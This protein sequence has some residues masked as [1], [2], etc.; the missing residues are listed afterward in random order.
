[1]GKRRSSRKIEAFALHARNGTTHVDYHDLFQYLV[2]L[3]PDKRR[4]E[5]DDEV[6]A[7]PVVT[8]TGARICVTASTGEK[9]TNPLVHDMGSGQDEVIQLPQTKFLTDRMHVLIDVETREAAVEYN[10]RG[11]KAWDIARAIESIVSKQNAQYKSLSVELV[12]IVDEG[13]LT[14]I[15]RFGRIR[16]AS[17]TVA[18]P[19]NSWGTHAEQLLKVADGSDARTVEITLTAFKGKSLSVTDGI[20][21]MI[22]EWARLKLPFLQQATLRGTRTDETAESVVSLG[23]YILHQK[24]DVT[25]VD[26]HVDSSE[27]EGKL[28]AFL[29]ARAHRSREGT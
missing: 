7:F 4:S 21:G 27:I 9:G 6:I 16:L 23:H 20:V 28:K 14:A 12:P 26:G 8:K 1:M 5:K 19:N 15:G 2:D 25:L 29:D 10:H 13:F 11:A 17:A 3:A 24:V 18:R 22:K